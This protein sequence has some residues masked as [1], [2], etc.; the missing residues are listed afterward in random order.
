MYREILCTLA[1]VF[2]LSGADWKLIGFS[3]I[4]KNNIDWLFYDQSSLEIKENGIIRIWIESIKATNFNEKDSGFIREAAE[5]LA[6]GYVP[7][8]AVVKNS[9]PDQIQDIIMMETIANMQKMVA[10]MK[11]LSFCSGKAVLGTKKCT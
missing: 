1:I 11:I 4:S 8:Y 2:S 7:P 3:E 9:N 5:L 6:K 10:R